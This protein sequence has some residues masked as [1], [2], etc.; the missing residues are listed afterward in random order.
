V[1]QTA[2]DPVVLDGYIPVLDIT[3]GRAT[4]TP[5]RRRLQIRR[6]KIDEVCRER[7][8]S[9]VVSRPRHIDPGT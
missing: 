7:A 4:V 9:W 3:A 6:A 5:A 2:N 1:S 8:A